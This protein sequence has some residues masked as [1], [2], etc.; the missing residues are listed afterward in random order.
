VKPQKVAV[1]GTG[2]AGNVA[3]YRLH[4]AGHDLAVF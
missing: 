2:I 4:R 1:V 3:A